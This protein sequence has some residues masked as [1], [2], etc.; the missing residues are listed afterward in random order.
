M[1]RKLVLAASTIA[2]AGAAANTVPAAAAEKLIVIASENVDLAGS[3]VAIDVSKARGAYRGIRLRSKNGTVGFTRVQV[4]YADGSVHTEDRPFSLTGGER[5]RPIG[6]GGSDRFIDRINITNESGKGQIVLD[7]LGIQTGNGSRMARPRA[8][9]GEIAGTD[10][11]LKPDASAPGTVKDGNDVMF[12]Y[13]NVG[14]AL[15]RDIIKVGGEAGKF[16]RIRLRVLGND[17]HIVSLKVVYIDSSSE[18]LA[19]DAEVKANKK[20]QWLELKNENF[21]R[22]IQMV[23]RSSP[24]LKGQ[25]R[26]EVTGQYAK[27]WLG[28][29]GEGRQYNEGWVLLGAQ[30]AGFTGFDHDTIGVGENEG[31]FTR[32]RIVAKDRA[33]TLKEI[34]VKFASGPDEVFTMRERIDPGTPYGPLEFKGGQAPIRVIEARYRSRFDL[35]KGLKSVIEGKPA[36]VEIWGQH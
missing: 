10:T 28:S 12:G 7:V 14:F 33:I 16:D 23:Y 25:A 2:L 17:I 20:T 36:V 27:G 8:A 21:I 31:G 19:I 22:E 26:V 15:D 35:M 24:S 9:T 34:R 3:G 4:I 29:G 18:D 6:D 1:L 13:Q 30:T 32:L 5:S 11:S